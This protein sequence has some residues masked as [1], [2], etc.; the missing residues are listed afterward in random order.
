M[1]FI[2]ELLLGLKH[3]FED[4]GIEI[5][6]LFA[7]LS[8]GVLSLG[9][10]EN[11]TFKKAILQI[12]TGGACASYLTPILIQI[13]PNWIPISATVGNGLA[14]IIGL[15]GM[16]LVPAIMKLGLYVKRNPLKLLSV[17]K[18]NK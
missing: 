10:S 3:N 15:I 6:F 9:Y 12:I 1:D 5:A 16:F 2:K 13:L 7:G 14:F 11:M 17:L 4:I 18:K 8:G